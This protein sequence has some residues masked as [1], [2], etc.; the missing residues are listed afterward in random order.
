[1]GYQI[2]LLVAQW[3]PWKIRNLS[4][5]DIVLTYLYDEANPVSKVNQSRNIFMSRYKSKN[6][7]FLGYIS[8]YIGE[9]I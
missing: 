2:F 5:T 7:H 1:M 8:T 6:T 9:W 3:A 4:D